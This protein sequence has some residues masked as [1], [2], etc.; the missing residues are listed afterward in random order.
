M[1]I[2]LIVCSFTEWKS[3]HTFHFDRV[4]SFS[5]VSFLPNSNLPPSTTAVVYKIQLAK[6]CR[7]YP[8]RNKIIFVENAEACN[9]L[10][11][12]LKTICDHI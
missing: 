6:L 5:T 7:F 11:F 1:T 10:N 4:S 3:N 9:L 8:L 2:M 12:P